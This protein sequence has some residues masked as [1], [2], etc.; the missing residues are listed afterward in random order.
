[1]DIQ[2]VFAHNVRKYRKA[3][4]LSQE[5]LAELA[6]LHRTYIGGIEQR[7]VNVSL[8]NIGKIA[9][10]LGVDPAVLFLSDDDT[11]SPASKKKAGLRHFK[12]LEDAR[13]LETATRQARPADYALCAWHDGKLTMRPIDVAYED[14]TVQ[15]VNDLVLRGYRGNDLAAQY[16]NAHY[17]IISF[18]ERDT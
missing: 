7:R 4:K 2:K 1:M 9:N 18:L 14:L 6:G 15:I 11:T 10:A 16:N 13:D 8:K 3:A 17:E 12:P 5:K